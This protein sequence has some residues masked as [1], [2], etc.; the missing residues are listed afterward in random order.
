M[1]DE[2]AYDGHRD[3]PNTTNPFEKYAVIVGNTGVELDQKSAY[4]ESK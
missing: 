4:W 3:T 1:H 2:I